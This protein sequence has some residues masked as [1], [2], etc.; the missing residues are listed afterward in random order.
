MDS[1]GPIS[2]YHLTN[3]MYRRIETHGALGT[4]RHLTRFATVIPLTH[5]K[6]FVVLEMRLRR[7]Q[8]H[9]VCICWSRCITV[10]KA[11]K[12]FFARYF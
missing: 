3:S 1:I 11:E 8:M 10:L 2:T 4:A 6:G 5:L 7:L 12:Q 9:Y